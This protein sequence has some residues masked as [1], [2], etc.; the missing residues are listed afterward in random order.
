MPFLIPSSCIYLD[1]AST[2]PVDPD[3]AAVMAPYLGPIFGNPSNIHQ[4]GQDARAALERARAS[5][6]RV[7]GCQTGEVLFTG[8]A[9]ESDNLALIGV[10]WAHRLAGMNDPM[11]HI[12]TTAIEH[13][14]VLNAAEWLERQGFAV[15]RV[16][17]DREGMVDAAAIEA[18]MRPETRL[19]SVMLANNEVGAIQPIREIAAVARA[20]GVTIHVDATQAVGL[21]SIRVDDLGVDLMS[22]SAHKFYGPKGVGA[23]YVRRGTMIARQ[24]HGGG[25]EGGR[26]GGTE[27]V[28]GIVGMAAAIE[29]AEQTRD[30]YVA[31]CS[32]LSRALL[33]EIRAEIPDV[34]LYGP[35]EG[36][37]RLPN[38]LNL[39]F[40]GVQGE[41]VLLS[42]DMQGI[43]ASSGSACTTGNAEPSHVL[44][45]MGLTPDQARSSLR[46]TVG[47]CNTPSQ[48]PDI[49]DALTDT[50]AR[51]REL[52]AV[53]QDRR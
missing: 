15:T 39:G 9:T 21:A 32:A 29:R 35:A 22:I 8:G 52:S 34:E 6:A 12:V 42:L 38:N 46:L 18:A 41:T 48:I 23:L 51:V 28:A 3:V 5:V 33:D 44:L 37:T 13:H 19:V 20:H 1:H 16:A 49:V 11:P 40:R 2:T 50:I 47:R 43:A 45:A 4:P 17:C 27:N 24:Q 26:R 30:A 10:A 36:T 14:A 7:F 25:Q 53:R 31:H